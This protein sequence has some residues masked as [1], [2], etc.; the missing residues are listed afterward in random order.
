MTQRDLILKLLNCPDIN[1][2]TQQVEIITKEGHAIRDIYL[3]GDNKLIL[4]IDYENKGI[5]W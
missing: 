4:V 2:P 1:D 5:K 3:R